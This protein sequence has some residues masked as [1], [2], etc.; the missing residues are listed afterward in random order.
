ML[1]GMRLTK[2]LSITSLCVES[3]ETDSQVLLNTIK[4]GFTNIVNLQP[5]LAEILSLI[6]DP[7]WHIFTSHFHYKGNSC[8]DA[9]ACLGHSDDFSWTILND[10]PPSCIMM[11]FSTP[12]LVP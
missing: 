10:P 5:I 9:L 3:L 11:R 6:N 12:C 4:N 8:V 7:S 2:Q 1:H